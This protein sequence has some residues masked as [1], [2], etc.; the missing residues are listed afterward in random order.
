RSAAEHAFEPRLVE[1]G[2]P[3]RQVG[4][5]SIQPASGRVRNGLWISGPSTPDVRMPTAPPP[6]PGSIVR[7]ANNAR[8]QEVPSL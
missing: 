8:S 1:R 4:H 6:E 2:Q 5:A 3:G 7:Q